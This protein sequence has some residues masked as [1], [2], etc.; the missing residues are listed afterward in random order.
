MLDRRACEKCS[1]II[2]FCDA[3]SIP[4]ITLANAKGFEC[5]KAATKLTAAYA[6]ATT[7][8]IT[9]VTGEAYGAYYMACAGTGAASDLTIALDTASVSPIAPEAGIIIMDPDKLKTDADGRKKAIEEFKTNEC[10]AMRAAE[11]GHIDNVTTESELRTVLVSALD[12]LAGKRE[13]TLPKKH[14]TI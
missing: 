13:T 7:A 3:Y 5:V 9:V 6:E 8:K 12:M 2:R 1:K 4:V 11:Q 14:S 10:S